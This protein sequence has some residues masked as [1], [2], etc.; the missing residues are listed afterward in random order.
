MPGSHAAMFV[1]GL[2]IGALIA[3]MVPAILAVWMKQIRAKAAVAAK[4]FS[5]LLPSTKEERHWWWL[6]CITAG[7][8][9]EIV[10]RGFLLHYFG[11]TPLHF[12]LSWALVISSLI[13]GIGH[14]YQG[15]V[16]AASTV[17]IGF[18]LG[19]IFIVTGS[20]LLPILIHAVMDLRVLLMVPANFEDAAA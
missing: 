11:V 20:L 1:K 16:Q 9:E 14:L 4:K 3:I 8:C 5:F 6:V 18:M 7:I 17:V 15:T 10:Y 13:F 12:S 2:T 19:A